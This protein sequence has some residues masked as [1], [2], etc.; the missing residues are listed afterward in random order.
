MQSEFG[1]WLVAR[2]GLGACRSLLV[3]RFFRHSHSVSSEHLQYDARLAHRCIDPHL[4]NDDGSYL[5]YLSMMPV[6]NAQQGYVCH[7]R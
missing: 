7:G 5:R 3:A 4:V 2:M 6:V 1:S